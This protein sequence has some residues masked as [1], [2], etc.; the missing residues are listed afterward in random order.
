MRYARIHSA[1]VRLAT[2]AALTLSAVG[3]IG[4][5]NAGQGAISGGGIGA[6]SGAIIGSVFGEAGAGAAIGAVAG[7]IAGGVIG[8]QNERRQREALYAQPAVI[9]RHDYDDQPAE[10]PYYHRDRYLRRHGG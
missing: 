1:L 8:D 2:C 10:R 3:L 7:A 6:A 5:A 9:E 4:C